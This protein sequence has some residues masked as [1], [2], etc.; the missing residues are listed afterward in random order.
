MLGIIGAMEEEVV[1]IKAQMQDV[2]V[3][4]VAGMNFYRGTLS[5]HEVVV[6]Q[7]GIGKVNA[8]ICSQILVDRFPVTALVN[9]G[10][11]G[12]L[13]NEINI[14]DVVL[15]VDALHHDMDGTCFGYPAG[16][17]PQMDTLA[18]PADKALM[19]LAR[20][21]CEKVNPE[22]GIFTGRVLSGDQFIADKQKKEWMVENFQGICVEMEGAAIAQTAYRNQ[23]P[24]LIIR[25]ISDKADD[26]AQ[27]DYSEFEK[28][29]IE[30]S[31]RLVLELAARYE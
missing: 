15:S 14:G 25:E 13:K 6:V 30:R 23:I 9:T 2:E 10:I 19:E 26:S 28:N 16:Q 21:C 27:M 24:Y 17:V 18:F 20:E 22:V 29:A 12:S 11:A 4:T 3:T 1:K 31:V 7:S 5:G 8:A